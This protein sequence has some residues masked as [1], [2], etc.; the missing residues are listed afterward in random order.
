M[1]E[2]V[3]S[4]S[5][6]L[7]AGDDLHL[8]Y[9]AGDGQ[10]GLVP[11]AH[12]YRQTDNVEIASSP[13]DITE[14]VLGGYSIDITPPTEV[15]HYA[16]YIIYTDSGHTSESAD[17]G[18]ATDFYRY[19]N[20]D[21]SL[22]SL[23]QGAIHIDAV[24]GTAGAV[25]GVNGTISNPCDDLD[26]AKTLGDALGI[27]V[28]KG[29]RG[30]SFTLTQTFSFYTFDFSSDL[31]GSAHGGAGG[32]LLDIDGQTTLG[33]TFKGLQIWNMDA[34]STITA[35]NCVLGNPAATALDVFFGSAFDCIFADD[36]DIEG[37][38]SS[39]I[40]CSTISA[41]D[42]VSIRGKQ[43]GVF[44]PPSVIG[45]R[46]RMLFKDHG[47]NVANPEF[48]LNG[49]ILELD[50]DVVGGT[51]KTLFVTGVGS[52]VNNSP[53]LPGSIDTSAL[54]STSDLLTRN[55]FLALK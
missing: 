24:N 15:S 7:D 19:L 42:R 10:T 4:V 8:N 52:L 50:T 22:A 23:Y 45:F 26:D 27:Y 11:Q 9:Q 51:T 13:F 1:S 46:G 47:Q 32:G 5:H 28:I 2:G 54:V 20:P 14:R 44:S 35:V 38:S 31:H 33:C 43:S 34:T 36:A 3:T 29:K 37:G 17:H 48:N 55:T 53:W 18:R 41:D 49:A 25:V 6:R 40:N 39:F 30:F 16:R 12:V 21:V